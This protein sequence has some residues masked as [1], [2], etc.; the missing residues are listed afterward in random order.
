MPV[1][2]VTSGIRLEPVPKPGGTRWLTRLD[3]AAEASYATAVIPIVPA[4]ERS[5]P[6]EVVANRVVQ[7]TKDPPRIRLEAWKRARGRFRAMAQDL[8]RGSRTILAVDVRGCYA[9]IGSDSVV[10]ALE[11]VGCRTSDARAVAQAIERFESQ[12]VTGLPVGPAPSAVLANA[13][14]AKVDED[15]RAAGYRHLRWVDDL[16]VFTDGTPSAV[17]GLRIIEGSLAALGLEL[18]EE[19][20]RLLD[21]SAAM[22]F[23][24]VG[25]H[26][27]RAFGERPSR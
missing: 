15:L 8:A 4:V 17:R 27:S 6:A 23:V 14:L 13:V 5:L 7:I 9:G 12:G 25:S 21:P 10:S 26:P 1:E 20:T 2:P 16:T 22:P 11:R 24:D 19:K 3:A 18:A